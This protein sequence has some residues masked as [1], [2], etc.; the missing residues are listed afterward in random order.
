MRWSLRVSSLAGVLVACALGGT[1]AASPAPEVGHF[2]G[3]D[4]FGP[5]IVTDLPCLEGTEF[6]GTGSEVFRG[7][8]VNSE[9]FFHFSGTNLFSATLV[10]VSGE[11]PTYV[12]G[13]NVEKINFTARAVPA[14][15][16][17][18]STNIINDQFI[19]YVDG[20][21]VTT[22]TI[23]VHEVQ[24]FVGVDTDGDNVPDVFTVSVTV[25]RVSCP[26]S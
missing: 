2:S 8:F 13:G 23:R 9:G 25:D 26:G 21:R 4:T 14:G 7:T 10:P 22:A 11:G 1:A 16:A 17:I 18:N 12:E 20:K 3:V 19:G 6:V 5:G 24:H 15:V